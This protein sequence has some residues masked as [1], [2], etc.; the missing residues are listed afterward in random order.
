MTPK[1]SIITACKNSSKTIERTIVSVTRQTYKNTEHIFIDGESEDTTLEIINS[2]KTNSSKILSEPDSGIYDAMN[3]GVKLATGDYIFI[4]N[5]DD[6]FASD[7]VLEEVVPYLKPDR[8]NY[9]KIEIIRP[10]GTRIMREYKGN[11]W[12]L[13]YA[14]RIPHPGLFVSQEQHEQIGHYDT[15]L[16]VASDHDFILRLAKRYPL[17]PIPV[18]IN[19]ME[20]GTSEILQDQ[21]F[22]EFRDVSIRHSTPAPLAYFIWCIKVLRMKIRKLC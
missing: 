12:Q 5:S 9:G 13:H 3:K 11:R 10:N 1:I 8:L 21:S 20:P 15:S 14:A 4:L 19:V 7:T 22:M 18:T 17:N 16:K 6:Y 2:H